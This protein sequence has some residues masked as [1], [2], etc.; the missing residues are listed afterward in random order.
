M[1][2]GDETPAV[3]EQAAPPR[4]AVPFALAAL[5]VAAAVLIAIE[6]PGYRTTSGG[7]PGPAMMPLLVAG[8]SLVAAI[9]LVVQ[10]LRGAHEVED[11]GAGR[12]LPVRVLVS[13]AALIAGAF[14]F[15]ELGF[16]V[17]FTVLMFVMG[18]LAGS[19]RW[20][21]NLLVAV[22]TTWLV[23]IVFGRLFSVPLPAG[24]VDVFLGG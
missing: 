11:D 15:R 21:A 24:P 10:T 22:I 9:A 19:R 13:F 17:V 14:L 2:S 1:S 18:W 3:E 8:L 4:R 6:A 23:M 7:E 16:F 5:L 12:V 20:W